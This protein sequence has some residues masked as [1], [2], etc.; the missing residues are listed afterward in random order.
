MKFIALIVILFPILWGVSASAQ[1]LQSYCYSDPKDFLVV[2]GL[3]FDK[4]YPIASVSKLVTS[5]WA[6]STKGPNFKYLTVVHVTPANDGE[7][8]I[9]FQG[10]RDPYFGQEK[11]HYVISNLNQKG[12]TKVRNLTFDENFLYLRDL[13]IERNPLKEKAG[14]PWK[15]YYVSQ[16]GAMRTLA[17]LKKGL[18]D[19]YSLSL[20]HLTLS[21]IK[22]LPKVDFTARHISFTNSKDFTSTRVTKAFSVRSAPMFQL[23]KEMN[24]NSNNFSAVEIFKTL[25]GREKF[26]TFIKQQLGLGKE[27]IDFYEGSGNRVANEP[28]YNQATCRALL[29]IFKD[30]TVMAQKFALDIDDI[31][32]VMGEDGLVDRGYPYINDSNAKSGIAKTGTSAAAMTL[33]GMLNTKPN[34]MYFMYNVNPT[35]FT[36]AKKR[37]SRAMIGDE[38]RKL[39]KQFAQSLSVLEY[40]KVSFVSF[41]STSFDEMPPL[42]LKP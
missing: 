32:S 24:R 10:S 29:I 33:G 39:S 36:A 13:D 7:F 40:K 4:K 30:L 20:K 16:V 23:L 15:N 2:N 42:V 19:T 26:T 18:T 38:V 11:L 27:S 17:E 12:I 35:K 6:I 34:R 1:T 31:V 14:F 9:H 25:G 41:D 5:Y 28:I 22:L 3:N 21:R 8:D 37:A